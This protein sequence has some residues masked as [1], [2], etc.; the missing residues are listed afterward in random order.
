VTDSKLGKVYEAARTAA[1]A[2]G[3][4]LTMPAVRAKARHQATQCVDVMAM[5]IDDRQAKML[6]WAEAN[7]YP[8]WLTVL[9]FADL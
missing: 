3:D 4:P 2:A 5:S 1:R 6:D 9:R 7:G 8:D